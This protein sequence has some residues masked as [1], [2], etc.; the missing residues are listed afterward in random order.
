METSTPVAERREVC[1]VEADDSPIGRD[2]HNSAQTPSMLSNDSE[3]GI[4]TSRT[5]AGISDEINSMA[6]TPEKE[7][8]PD[9]MGRKLALHS[10][11]IIKASVN[12]AN[13]PELREE[14]D[15]RLDLSVNTFG[16][17]SDGS[18]RAGMISG[19]VQPV[20][21][22]QMNKNPLMRG[23]ERSVSMDE[24]NKAPTRGVGEL[25]KEPAVA[26]EGIPTRTQ[27]K[28]APRKTKELMGPK[29]GTLASGSKLQLGMGASESMLQSRACPNFQS[30]KRSNPMQS[31]SPT[32]KRTRMRKSKVLPAQQ[33][34]TNIWKNVDENNKSEE[35]V[36]S[37]RD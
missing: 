15:H 28:K 25:N 18:I 17:R 31:N 2:C 22:D 9:T 1:L 12:N 16:K 37:K 10:I 6:V 5:K 13:V 23:F 24:M 27:T 26:V 7:M 35:R 36:K 21:M 29:G 33:L 3:D 34:L 30:P 19:V 20:G 14:E 11:D 8:S 32:P 4:P